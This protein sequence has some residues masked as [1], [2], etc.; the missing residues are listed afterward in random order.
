MKSFLFLMIATLVAFSCN[1]QKTKSLDSEH[2]I[3]TINN[4]DESLKGKWVLEY[5][6]PVN[7]KN[8]NELYKIQRP[9]LTFVDE[10]KVAGNNGCNNVAGEYKTESNQIQFF[11][12]KFISTKMFCEGV[13]EN[14]FTSELKK[15]N[16]Y[17]VIENGKTLV[18][19]IGDIVS[20]KF[21]KVDQ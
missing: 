11:T 13:D 9:Y 2:E 12:D 3:P 17:D 19:M 4:F 7:G 15:N 20:M 21:K 6:S 16:R 5:M 18:L 10:S 14:A 1:V 8:I